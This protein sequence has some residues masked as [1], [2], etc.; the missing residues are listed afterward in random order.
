MNDYEFTEEGAEKFKELLKEPNPKAART[1]HH[2]RL[3]RMNEIIIPIGTDDCGAYYYE[4]KTQEEAMT[5]IIEN[6]PFSRKFVEMGHAAGPP[7]PGMGIL[8]EDLIF[9][10][11]EWDIYMAY[12]KRMRGT[13][14]ENSAIC[15]TIVQG[16]RVVN[17][18]SIDAM[19]EWAGVQEVIPTDEIFRIKP[20]KLPVSE[21][22]PE[23]LQAEERLAKW[24]HDKYV[25]FATEEGIHLS[26]N[27]WDSLNASEKLTMMK[28]GR[29]IHKRDMDELLYGVR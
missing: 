22:F 6:D 3:M 4:S 2:A 8:K 23:F 18:T 28:M 14:I 12:L 15:R 26:I 24:L 13:E 25:E 27:S 19:R 17:F 10:V 16:G 11:Y 9:R 1:V 21:E 5:W 29:M 7:R 20:F